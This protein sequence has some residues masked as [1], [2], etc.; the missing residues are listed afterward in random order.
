MSTGPSANDLDSREGIL[1]LLEQLLINN[2]KLSF[3]VILLESIRFELIQIVTYIKTCCHS[4][5][6]K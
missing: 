5:V 6:E 1:W 3:V 4:Y 2:K